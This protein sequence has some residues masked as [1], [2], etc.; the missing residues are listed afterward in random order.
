VLHVCSL[1][2]GPPLLGTEAGPGLDIPG[3][4]LGGGGGEEIWPHT[5]LVHL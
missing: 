2:D 4:A 1:C 5:G 3:T